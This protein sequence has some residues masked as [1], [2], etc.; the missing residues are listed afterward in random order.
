MLHNRMYLGEIVHKGQSFPGQH[1]VIIMPAQS[2]AVHALLAMDAS[3]RRRW[4][5]RNPLPT[6]WVAPRE[7]VAGFDA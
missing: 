6:D 5:Q 1:P 7:V 4:F 2:E 3:E